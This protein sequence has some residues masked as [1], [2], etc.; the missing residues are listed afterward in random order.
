MS[1][2]PAPLFSAAEET[3]HSIH[4]NHVLA[5]KRVEVVFSHL[6]EDLA[7][8]KP[9]TVKG[10]RVRSRAKKAVTTILFRTADDD[11]AVVQR[12]IEKA[13][14]VGKREAEVQLERAQNPL[15]AHEM[16]RLLNAGPLRALLREWAGDAA[17]KVEKSLLYGIS[18]D[19]DPK[20]TAARIA[21]HLGGKDPEKVKGYEARALL[22]ARTEMMRANREALRLTWEGSGDVTEWVWKA[23]LDTT[24]CGVCWAMHGSHHPVGTPMGTHPACYCVMLPVI[25]GK[26]GPRIV[27]GPDRFARLPVAKQEEVLGPTRYGLY[28]SGDLTMDESPLTGIVIPGVHKDWGPTRGYRPIS[29]WL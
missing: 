29:H 6:E 21:R 23:R 20:V 8:T 16:K 28:R 24:T 19:E 18:R 7:G 3:R 9:S 13:V 2:V 27:P 26:R 15:P 12:A 17:G 5:R 22:I 1:G 4:R 14:R 11:A 25:R 10:R